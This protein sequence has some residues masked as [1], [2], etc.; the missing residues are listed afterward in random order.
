M[1][2]SLSSSEA[3]NW[4]IANHKFV[5]PSLSHR[6]W[7][8]NEQRRLL[9]HFLNREMPYGSAAPYLALLK[10]TSTRLF[11]EEARRTMVR[12]ESHDLELFRYCILWALSTFSG[13][14]RQNA[15]IAAFM[16]ELK[17]YS[18]RRQ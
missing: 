2:R 18:R 14:E 10:I 12:Y 13:T 11:T 7:R 17:G 1:L 5:P 8:R 3:C 9:K 6:S 15:D 4:L 16:S